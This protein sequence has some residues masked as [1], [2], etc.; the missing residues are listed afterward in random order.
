MSSLG[1]VEPGDASVRRRRRPHPKFA[2]VIMCFVMAIGIYL[3]VG[4]LH[5]REQLSAVSGGVLTTGTVVNVRV[6]D[7]GQQPLYAPVVT[8]STAAGRRIEF[9]APTGTR[10]PVLGSIVRVSYSPEDPSS[11]HDLSDAGASWQWPFYTGVFVLVFSALMLSLVARVWVRR[12]SQ[13]LAL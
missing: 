7:S 3:V 8:F 2:A 1:T 6:D 13:S 12:R 10:Q 5:R 11:A 9:T 4:G